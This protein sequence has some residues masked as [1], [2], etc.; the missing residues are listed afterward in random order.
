M[1]YPMSWRRVCSRNHLCHDYAEQPETGRPVKYGELSAVD[2]SRSHIAGDL[3]R[4]EK[5]SRDERHLAQYAALAGIT[6]EQAKIVL[7][8]LFCL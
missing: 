6:V 8:A 1:G 5:D 3:R 4:L 7:D 2:L